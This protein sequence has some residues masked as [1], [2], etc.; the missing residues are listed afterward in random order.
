MSAILYFL[1]NGIR[2]NIVLVIAKD[3]TMA[4]GYGELIFKYQLLLECI[5]IAHN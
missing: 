2:L 3:R 5:K 1:I 4:L